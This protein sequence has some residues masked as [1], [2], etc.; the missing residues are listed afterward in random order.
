M[1]RS[2]TLSETADK[3][4]LIA[5][6]RLAKDVVDSPQDFELFAELRKEAQRIADL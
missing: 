4:T 3:V 5:S 1:L 2:F 6:G